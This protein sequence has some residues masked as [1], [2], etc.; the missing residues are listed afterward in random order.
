MAVYQ[1]QG[2]L[3]EADAVSRPALE[4][5]R[6]SQGKD[7]EALYSLLK[8]TW[9]NHR[10][11]GRHAESVPLLLEALEILQRT[12]SE[13]DWETLSIIEGLT[14]AYLG[15]ERWAES[16]PFLLQSIEVSRALRGDE[17][18]YTLGAISNLGYVYNKL[19]RYEEAAAMYERSLPIKRRVLG[20]EHAWTGYAMN[21]LAWALEG[22]GRADEALL[23]YRELL[24]RQLEQADDPEASAS[25]LNDAAWALLQGPA[26]SLRDPGLALGYAE[27]ACAIAERDRL[28]NLWSLL[29]TLALAQHRSGDTAK[30]LKTQRRAVVLV[31]EGQGAGLE[32]R[33]AE[34]E[35][36]VSD[37]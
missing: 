12:Q 19:E 1:Q 24:D 11:S 9:T 26:E 34:Y 23:M 25:V 27:R 33:L 8:S 20:M 6:G 32:E 2:R 17:D 37:E 4:L 29:D 3:A 15:L 21:G 36:L 14:E 30:A 22:M 5:L 35:S 18:Q 16:E 13:A 28:S 10:R 31:P 7:D